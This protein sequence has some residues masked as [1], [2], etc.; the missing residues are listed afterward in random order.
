MTPEWLP[1]WNWNCSEYPNGLVILAFASEEFSAQ[2][3]GQNR[4][5]FTA[6]L[7][8]DLRMRCAAPT[9]TA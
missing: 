3:R 7:T 1:A 6:S 9:L 2:L 8:K 5:E 4:K